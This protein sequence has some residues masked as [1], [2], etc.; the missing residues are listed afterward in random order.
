MIWNL[1]WLFSFGFWIMKPWTNVYLSGCGPEER[2]TYGEI[3]IFKVPLRKIYRPKKISQEF[4]DIYLLKKVDR[5]RK[6]CK[7][8]LVDMD[9]EDLRFINSN[10]KMINEKS[11]EES[12]VS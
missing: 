11:N 8:S 9:D 6:I 12:S 3:N 10:R 5:F 7:Y 1:L 2:R 4:Y